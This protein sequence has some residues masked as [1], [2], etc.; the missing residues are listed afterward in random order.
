MSSPEPSPEI[1]VM[2][3]LHGGDAATLAPFA[4]R[5]ID[6]WADILLP[7]RL[8][9]G[10]ES[11][12]W[13][14]PPLNPGSWLNSRTMLSVCADLWPEETRRRLATHQIH[15]PNGWGQLYWRA[16]RHP[17]PSALAE[18]LL[19]LHLDQVRGRPRARRRS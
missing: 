4:L 14:P 7:L 18:M 17:Q 1:A 2:R 6:L 8:E 11:A 19:E 9:P 12:V 10:G 13:R 15:S 16:A 5:G 3:A